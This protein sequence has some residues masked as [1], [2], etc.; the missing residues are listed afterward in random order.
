MVNLMILREGYA[1]VLTVRPNMKYQSVFLACQGE[2]REAGRGLW[3][4]P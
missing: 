1:Q 3:A 2:A 4:Q